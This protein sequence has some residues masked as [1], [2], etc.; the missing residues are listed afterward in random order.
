[1]NIGFVATRLAGVD[2]VSLEVH[3]LAWMFRYTVIAISRGYVHPLD[4]QERL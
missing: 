3:K 2:G 1:M 4:S